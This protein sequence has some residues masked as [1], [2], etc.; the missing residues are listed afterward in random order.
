[1]ADHQHAS[2]SLPSDF[3]SVR[4]ARTYVG[5]VLS[6]WG[7][8]DDAETIH[9]VQL[10]VSELATNAVQHTCGRSP[11]FTVHLRLDEDGE[12]HIGVTDSH[13][14]WPQRLPAAVQQDNGRGMLIV[15][16]LT[17]EFAGS[18]SVVPTEEGGKTVRVTLP[19]P[20]CR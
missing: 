15:R 2:L 16:T 9:T 18:M 7:L 19:G 11:T 17:A 12:L 8:P 14:R 5:N 4:E 10:I 3:V 6:K 1:M 20:P 13:P